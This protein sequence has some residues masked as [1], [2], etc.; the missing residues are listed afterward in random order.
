MTYVC[1]SNQEYLEIQNIFSNR[2]NYF[3]PGICVGL[4]KWIMDDS[5]SFFFP[6]KK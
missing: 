6:L 4:A 1:P 5:I 2:N 3:A